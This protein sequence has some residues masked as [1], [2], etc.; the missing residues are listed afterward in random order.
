MKISFLVV[1]LL[2]TLFVAA[3]AIA[4]E[5]AEEAPTSPATCAVCGKPKAVSSD[6]GFRF[7]GGYGNVANRSFRSSKRPVFGMP[8]RAVAKVRQARAQRIL[9]RHN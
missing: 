9:S 8:V 5:V 2:A 1:A 6:A 7:D 4:A 3:P